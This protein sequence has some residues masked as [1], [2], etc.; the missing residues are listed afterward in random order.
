MTWI[1]PGWGDFLPEDN[2]IVGENGQGG[3]SIKQ[4]QHLGDVEVSVFC[5]V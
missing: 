4:Q 3:Y 5:G 1:S 2:S